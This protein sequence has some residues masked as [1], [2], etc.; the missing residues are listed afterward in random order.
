MSVFVGLGSNLGDRAAMLDRAVA[1]IARLP[2]VKVL[3]RSKALTTP[4]MLPPEDPTPQPDYLNAVVELQTRLE[5]RALLKALKALE[6]QLGRKQAKRWAPREIDLD[7]LL[8][9]GEV[10]DAPDFQLP[11][12]GL[13][14][15]RFVLAPLA[16]LAPRLRHPTLGKTVSQLLAAL[17]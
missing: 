7:L 4:A 16:E 12:P 6:V 9:N 17:A 14:Q 13:A 5:P 1:E 2:G 10:I 8:W 15:R 3:R 11:H